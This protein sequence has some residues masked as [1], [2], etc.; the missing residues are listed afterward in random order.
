MKLQRIDNVLEGLIPLMSPQIQIYF[1]T[2]AYKSGFKPYLQ[3]VFKYFLDPSK[4]TPEERAKIKVIEGA[5]TDL[6][7]FVIKNKDTWKNFFQIIDLSLSD[8]DGN[9]YRLDSEVLEKLEIW[10]VAEYSFISMLDL[11]QRFFYF[12][13]EDPNILREYPLDQDILDFT[14]EILKRYWI[15]N[16]ATE[17]SL[18][19]IWL[20]K[21]IGLS[22]MNE[23]LAS[24][25]DKSGTPLEC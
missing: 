21:R 4:L 19:Y 17:S 1:L 14:I 11:V 12:E 5:T 3:L 23:L 13:D 2:N 8:F 24:S 6:M 20:L 15:N 18:I 9:P 16:K 22:K 10:D 25:S 7:N